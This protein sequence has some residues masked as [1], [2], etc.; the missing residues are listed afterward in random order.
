LRGPP[1]SPPVDPVF[2][3]G[4]HGMAFV[5]PFQP[6]LA[7]GPPPS[8]VCASCPA[9]VGA[10]LACPC[11]AVLVFVPPHTHTHIHTHART[12][13]AVCG[14]ALCVVFRCPLGALDCACACA[15]VCACGVFRGSPLY[16]TAAEEGPEVNVI[17]VEFAQSVIGL[18]QPAQLPQLPYRSPEGSRLAAATPTASLSLHR[19]SRRTRMGSPE[20]GDGPALAGGAGGRGLPPL[21]CGT[22]AALTDPLAPPPAPLGPPTSPGH[23]LGSGPGLGL[24]GDTSYSLPFLGATPPALLWA[25]EASL[26]GPALRSPSRSLMSQRHSESLLLE[27]SGGGGGGSGA[28][29]GSLGGLGSGSGSLLSLRHGPAAVVD[30]RRRGGG[31]GGAT[32]ANGGPSPVKAAQLVVDLEAARA[33][34][35]S[36]GVHGDDGRTPLHLQDC[37]LP[38]D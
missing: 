23:S 18:P 36:R 38:E 11:P 1:T 25:E 35:L 32:A 12:L 34:L 13:F 8:L 21:L 26:G 33:G 7:L 28:P 9:T 31:G 37:V 17:A 29:S 19:K 4:Y 27:G 2:A 3:V 10:P 6:R 15:C 16:R 14:R 24:G 5:A 30:R 20:S 22:H